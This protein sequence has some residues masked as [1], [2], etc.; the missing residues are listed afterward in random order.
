MR[1]TVEDL[2]Q[3]AKASRLVAET[4]L[5]K[6]SCQFDLGE[7]RRR[8]CDLSERDKAETFMEAIVAR[9]L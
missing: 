8:L 9:F 3:S 6:Y 5:S 7:E 1:K 2:F 4:L